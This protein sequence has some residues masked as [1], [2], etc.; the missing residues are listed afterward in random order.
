M[1]ELVKNETASKPAPN[2]ANSMDPK[3]VAALTVEVSKFLKAIANPDRLQILCMLVNEEMNVT[4]LENVTGIPQPRL[5]Q[6]LARL[7]QEGLVNNRRQSKEILYSLASEEAQA[8][9][10]LLHQLYCKA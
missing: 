7:R 10:G 2:P 6:H 1:L 3:E 8:V 4:S 5:S 9:I